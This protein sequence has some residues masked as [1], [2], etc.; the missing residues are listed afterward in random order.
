MDMET[1]KLAITTLHEQ[2]RIP[3]IMITS[4]SLPTPGAEPYL[5][6]MGSTFTSTAAPRIFGVKI[7]AIDCFFSGTGD[8]FAALMLVRLREAVFK[9][10]GLSDKTSWVSDDGVAPTDLPLAKATEKV[11]ASMNQ[12]LEKTKLSRDAELEIYNAQV[13]GRNKED[14]EKRLRLLTS[15]ATE[16]RLV[17]N[18]GALKHPEVKFKAERV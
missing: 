11:L 16:V 10:E 14:D 6:V 17:R 9:V 8:M 1:L 3:H 5:S 18:L 15:K 4:I 12:V 7:P 13:G 2:Y